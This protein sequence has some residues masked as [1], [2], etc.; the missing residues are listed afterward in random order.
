MGV[1]MYHVKNAATG[2]ALGACMGMTAVIVSAFLTR[3]PTRMSSTALRQVRSQALQSAGF[4]GTV[5]AV[6]QFIRS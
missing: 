6:G 2:F 1:M 4:M 5:F 3:R